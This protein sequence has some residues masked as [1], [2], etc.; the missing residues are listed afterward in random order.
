MPEV[1]KTYQVRVEGLW[2]AAHTIR[3]PKG[4]LG[5]LRTRRNAAGVVAGGRYE[6]SR[7]EVLVLRRDP[8]LRR[9]QFSLWTEAREWLGSSLR[10]S[11][12]SREV[13]LHTGSRPLRVL[14]TPGFGRGWRLQAPQAGEMARILYPRPLGR[15][16]RLEVYRRMDFEILLFAYFLGSQ[17]HRESFWPGPAAPPATDPGRG[18]LPPQGPLPVPP[19]PGKGPPT[20]P[21]P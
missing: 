18:A 4:D 1:R 5:V 3:G 11:P 6:P 2:S 12:F 21:L 15:A 14:P 10:W 9:G 16:A 17:S 7:G 8:G 19:A 20:R 13:V